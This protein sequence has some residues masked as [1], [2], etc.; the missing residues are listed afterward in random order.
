[1]TEIVIAI[2]GSGALSALI[3]GIFQCVN[4]RSNNRRSANKL[5]LGIAYQMI[6][7]SAE[8][9]IK[10]GYIATDEFNELNRY[11]F[12]PYK[13]AGGDGTAEKLMEE[14]RKL[15]TGGEND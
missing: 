5:L 1:M 7:E 9:H 12:E 11:L 4:N 6:I 15:P 13:A 10:R 8:F 2:I 14:V 3:A